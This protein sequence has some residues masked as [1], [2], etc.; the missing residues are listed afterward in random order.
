MNQ[1]RHKPK[2]TRPSKYRIPPTVGTAHRDTAVTARHVVSF[3]AGVGPSG[4]G[5]SITR[6]PELPEE[7]VGTYYLG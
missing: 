2:S 4:V 5:P 3:S 7:L 6:S 1:P